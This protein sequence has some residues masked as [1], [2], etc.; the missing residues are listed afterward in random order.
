M[1]T[2]DMNIRM[3]IK[4]AFALLITA[5]ML[6]PLPGTATV[7][8]QDTDLPPHTIW[9]F[10]STDDR[11]AKG[12]YRLA[13]SP[14]GTLIAARDQRNMVAIFDIA[15]RK[16]LCEFEPHV[17]WVTDIR[18]S[19]DSRFCLCSARDEDSTVRA[20]DTQTGKLEVEFGNN[21]FRTTFS[22]DGKKIIAFGESEVKTYTWPGVKQIDARVW[23]TDRES[24]IGMSA[25][26]SLV[27]RSS[28][29]Q[30]GQPVEITLQNLDDKSTVNLGQSQLALKNAA[31]S[32]NGLWLAVAYH[33][34]QSVSLWDLRDPHGTHQKLGGH[35]ATVQS[36]SFSDDSRFLITTG[37][38]NKAVLRDV[39]TGR[40][41]G[42]LPGHTGHVNASAFSSP[43]MLVATGA[44][45][46]S[47]NSVIV[48]DLNS[49]L[50]PDKDLPPELDS[51]DNVWK[52]LGS[53]FPQPAL[54]SV[55][56]IL[57]QD[58]DWTAQLDARL[59]EY[60]VE[61]SHDEI[62]RLIE[63][64]DNRKFA[65]RD[66]ATQK[67]RAMR[68]AAESQLRMAL[69]DPPSTEVRIRVKSILSQAVER[70]QIEPEL[71]RRLHR[72][73][74]ALEML[75]T[76]SSAETLQNIAIGHPDIDVAR[77]A[78]E[79]LERLKLRN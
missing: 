20:F 30:Q 3:K 8:G 48:R 4:L 73:I 52:E 27:V 54:D 69:E 9:R 55:A 60:L 56:A 18:F 61:A 65:T 72:S 62:A 26:G 51:F 40:E 14:D 32:P 59:N 45:G 35:E 31:F 66:Q 5:A 7:C 74:F 6:V 58:E 37:W 67:L 25:D 39:S 50:F 43:G 11:A 22:A 77:D 23:K 57:R 38:D 19:P 75:G 53:E 42:E 12:I 15:A 17:A 47:D 28:A 36:I 41:I 10:D 13:F 2:G 21:I 63:Q 44:S 79:S 49:I 24:G 16:K 46:N 71:L 76:E 64:L 78:Q 70:P 68:A 33:R 29:A 1:N 34:D